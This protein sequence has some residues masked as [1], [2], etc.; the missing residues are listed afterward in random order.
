MKPRR[1]T[2]SQVLDLAGYS[3]ATLRRRIA[4]GRMPAPID[5]GRE[6]LFDKDEIDAALK[7]GSHAQVRDPEGWTVDPDA[8][9]RAE[10]AQARS[11]S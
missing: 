5:R 8:I 4:A 3:N 10:A 11:A 7:G 6:D 9:R 2:R 1:Y